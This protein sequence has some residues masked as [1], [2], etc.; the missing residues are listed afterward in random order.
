M[1]QSFPLAC[2]EEGGAP[3]P[4][5]RGLYLAIGQAVEFLESLVPFGKRLRCRRDR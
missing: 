3:S 2:D 5:G 4:L 1:D